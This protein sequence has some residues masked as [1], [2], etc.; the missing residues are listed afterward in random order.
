MSRRFLTLVRHA[1]AETY[2]S[3]DDFSRALRGKG[4]NRIRENSELMIRRSYI[5]DLIISSPAVRALQTAE[6]YAQCCGI[7][8]EDIQTDKTLYLPS[9]DDILST[10]WAADDGFNDIFIFSHN[11]GI[12]YTAQ[13]ICGEPGIMMRTAAAVRIGLDL[14]CW[15]DLA[16]GSGS[17]TDY[18]S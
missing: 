10:V 7:P 2:G 8:I 18:I 6:I 15:A 5:A 4:M 3:A 17:L 1:K 12:S 14:D 9:V 13:E 11:N 16:P